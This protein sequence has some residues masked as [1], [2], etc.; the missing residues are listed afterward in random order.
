[1]DP[2]SALLSA[3]GIPS[4]E[5]ATAYIASLPPYVGDHLT[6]LVTDEVAAQVWRAWNADQ[7][8][9][10][11]D[12]RFLRAFRAMLAE[13]VS[14]GLSVN[15]FRDVSRR[16]PDPDED[17]MNWIPLFE[18][19]ATGRDRCS[20]RILLSPARFR[21]YTRADQGANPKEKWD[22]LV[23]MMRDGLFYELGIILP[24][25]S[26]RPDGSLEEDEIR[27]EWND[28]RL[29]PIRVIR[30][31]QAIVNDTRDGVAAKVGIQADA[32]V[33]PAN[34]NECALI[35]VADRQRCEQQKLTIWDSKGY[36]ILVV[37][38]AFRRSAGAFVNRILI[39]QYLSHI[40]QFRP[41][42][43]NEVSRTVN[44]D[45][46]VRVI[47]ALL[48]EEISVR[49]MSAILQAIVS[50]RA[51]MPLSI[52]KF[53]VFAHQ[54]SIPIIRADGGKGPVRV[55]EYVGHVRSELKRYISHKYTRGQNT[56]VVR[57]LDPKLEE[58]LAQPLPL[59]QEEAQQLLISIR[60]EVNPSAE[61]QGP[62]LLTTSEIRA[63]LLREI[64]VEFPTVA[65][66]SYQELSP[67]MNIQPVGRLSPDIEPY[68]DSSFYRFVDAWPVRRAATTGEAGDQITASADERAGHVVARNR[69]QIVETVFEELRREHPHDCSEASLMDLLERVLMACTD[70][71][72]ST[73][74]DALETLCQDTARALAADG[75]KISDAVEMPLILTEAIRQRAAAELGS[76]ASPDGM[77][78]LNHTLSQQDAR[79]DRVAAM[80][81]RAGLRA[82]FPRIF[83]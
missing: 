11:D 76:P 49:D 44:K 67:D 37:S 56:L 54:A 40:A 71:A 38:T 66:L 9:R 27:V 39:D 45:V 32:A 80:L 52:S 13:G 16:L 23:A 20:I 17:A 82:K 74:T 73:S 70:D 63:R 30:E 83:Q 5:A 79:S 8:P 69:R 12:R 41:E 31:D 78:S 65:V 42:L 24:P 26:I 50:A 7:V 1:M 21:S 29:P 25:F 81:L 58:R 77:R 43:A 47:R 75:T 53:I 15:R 18:E 10:L 51:I 72:A 61:S 62:V 48:R 22:Q 36:V 14:M 59:T 60:S 34:G 64:H 19:A 35:D 3:L 68:T 2:A 57:L 28:L 4:S 46:L 55:M 6:R 33:N